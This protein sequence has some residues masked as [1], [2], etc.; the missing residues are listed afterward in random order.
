MAN[1]ILEGLTTDQLADIIRES[2]RDEIAHLS[3][4]KPNPETE[5]LSRKEVLAL[6]KI[7]STTLWNW[8]KTGYIHSFP[9]GGR[10]RYKRTD[11]EA[12]RNGR[13]DRRRER[14]GTSRTVSP[15]SR[16]QR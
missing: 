14:S 7:E 16:R 12:I 11:V 2:V 3:P 1:I 5:Y 15:H 13:K 4:H 8:E 10:K 6:L 9:F